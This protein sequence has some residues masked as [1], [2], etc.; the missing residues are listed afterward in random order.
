MTD[1]NHGGGYRESSP[2]PPTQ[3]VEHTDPTGA[4]AV[5]TPAGWQTEIAVARTGSA[6]NQ[7]VRSRD[8]AT[9]TLV[10]CGDPQM[11]MFIIPG[12]MVMFPGPGQVSAQ[13]LPADAFIKQWA[14]QS[15]GQ[16]AE[17]TASEPRFLPAF[18]EI[19]LGTARNASAPIQACTSAAMDITIN[20][21]GRPRRGL[22]L[23]ATTAVMG[24]WLAHTHGVITPATDIGP[25]EDILLRIV[26][27]L[28]STGPERQRLRAE[29]AQ[30]DANHAAAMQSH[31][32][33]SAQM[34]ANHQQNMANIQSN[35]AAHQQKMNT[36]QEGFRIQNET[37]AATQASQDQQHRA[38]V[39]Q[40]ET[41]SHGGAGTYPDDAPTGGTGHRDFIDAVRGEETVTDAQGVQHK[42]EAGA[43]TYYYNRHHNTWIGVPAHKSLSDLG[44][45]PNQWEQGRPG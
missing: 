4:I 24:F 42:V 3:W 1:A 41:P 25:Y 10:F 19:A 26:G 40:F 38:Y 9:D 14:Q 21:D 28:T 11:P 20:P 12:G 29:R 31:Q 7:V 32:A 13:Y 27:S 18:H 36:M 6:V 23:C 22:L 16:M 15:Y 30:I 8:P 35:A 45:D 37:W 39:G 43:D 33:F 34:T 2:A 5:A 17:F 44:L